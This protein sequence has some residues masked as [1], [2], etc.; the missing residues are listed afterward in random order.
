MIVT[1]SLHNGGPGPNSLGTVVALASLTGMADQSPD[2]S[3]PVLGACVVEGASGA[4]AVEPGWLVVSDLATL[5]DRSDPDLRTLVR[6]CA[7]RNA[8]GM[9]VK[10]ARNDLPPGLVDEA[11][12][13]CLPVYLLPNQSTISGFL[14]QIHESTGISDIAV[15]SR[16]MSLQTELIGALS[17]AN[18]EAE[19]IARLSSALGVSAIL[20]DHRLEPVAVQGEAPVF[21]IADRIDPSAEG[22][23]QVDVGRWK[24]SLSHIRIGTQNTSLALAWPRDDAMDAG[25]IRST[26]FAVEQLLRAHSRTVAAARMQDQVQRS[27]LLAELLEGVTETRL[28]RLRDTLVLLHFPREGTFQ[29]HVIESDS[30]TRPDSDVDEVLALIH[31][32]SIDLDV[33][34]LMGRYGTTYV[35]LHAA[36]DT[37]TAALVEALPELDHGASSSFPELT[38]TPSAFRQAQTSLAASVRSGEFTAFHRVGFIDFIL[39]YLPEATLRER[40]LD[41]LGDLESNDMVME[42][43]I[44]YLRSGLDVQETARRMHLHPNSI[45]YRL[46]RAESQLGRS[47][48][49]PETITLLYLALHDRLRIAGPGL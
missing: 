34:A 33:P 24:V 14:R 27:Q 40:T 38:A 17:A 29:V 16:A 36:S 49:D 12:H 22:E 19:L 15:I 11:Q 23:Y 10:A 4:Q 21:L 39:G 3:R 6:E 13:A 8:S 48:N 44:E 35:T 30:R 5:A 46:T 20:F 32:R 7:Q 2:L 42:T 28:A 9:V 47:V 45:R 31:E 37:F 18:V 1:K 25:L 43:L 41:V 26:Q